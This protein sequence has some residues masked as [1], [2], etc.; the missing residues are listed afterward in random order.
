MAQRPWIFM[1]NT[2]EVN[3]R[4]S[5]VKMLSLS[6]DTHA[7]L[8]VGVADPDILMLHGLYDPIFTAY[9]QVCIDY[10]VVAGNRKGGTLAFEQVLDMI[11]TELRKWEGAIRAI[12]FEDTP[13]EM[14]IF[15][16]KRTPFLQ[17]TYEQRIGAIGTLAQKLNGMAGLAS[18]HAQVQSF[19]NMALGTR[20]AQQ[21]GEGSLAAMSDLRE[22]QRILLAEML[23]GVLGYLMFKHRGA[24]EHIDN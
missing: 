9:R 17:G 10:D 19:Y 1:S 12:H 22:Q 15:P 14:A 21:Q 23:Y 6:T 11:P 2:F 5:N 3:T 4:G 8:S 24:R 7:K 18:T 20:L 13:E 16:N